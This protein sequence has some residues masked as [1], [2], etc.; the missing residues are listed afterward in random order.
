MKKYISFIPIG[1]L[2]CSQ[3]YSL[4]IVN[5]SNIVL[6]SK[7]YAGA[8]F[9]IMSVVLLFLRKKTGS[10]C[11]TGISLLIGTLNFIAFLPVIE[12]YS[13]GFSFNNRN[14][15]DFRIQPFSFLILLIYLFSNYKTFHA[16]LRNS[17]EG[18][19]KKPNSMD[20]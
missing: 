5:T 12:S 6:G 3:L 8:I 11:L 17:S 15:I 18:E 16:L 20:I 2:V 7:Q 4:Y 10:I 1:I 14:G 13:F 9:V 19:Q